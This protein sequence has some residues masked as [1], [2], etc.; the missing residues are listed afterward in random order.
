MQPRR[1]LWKRHAE[2]VV[3][4]AV[5]FVKALPC[6]GPGKQRLRNKVRGKVTGAEFAQGLRQLAA[7]QP[8]V[9]AEG[10]GKCGSGGFIPEQ[11][12]MTLCVLT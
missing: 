4:H 6:Y 11:Q 12:L 10:T 3:D 1:K 8:M 9:S 7:Q 2:Q 5:D